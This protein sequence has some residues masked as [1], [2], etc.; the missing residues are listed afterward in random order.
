MK[1]ALSE[2]ESGPV[3][4]QIRDLKKIYPQRKGETANEWN[5]RIGD[6]VLERGTATRE[7]TSEGRVKTNTNLLI[8]S[9]IF[10]SEF[11]AGKVGR[12]IA[13]TGK[14]ISHFE[15]LPK[16]K[17][18]YKEGQHY[19]SKKGELHLYDGKNILTWNPRTSKFE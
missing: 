1:I 12:A 2:T 6:K 15:E 13:N 18:D 9:E 16:D 3:G 8:E 14:D 4:K 7:Q 17:E 10:D 19:F 5:K 11:A